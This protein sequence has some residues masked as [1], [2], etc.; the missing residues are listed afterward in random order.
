MQSAAHLNWPNCENYNTQISKTSMTDK[1]A[2]MALIDTE[3][4]TVKS[5]FDNKLNALYATYLKTGEAAKA[6]EHQNADD[7]EK[8]DSAKRNFELDKTRDLKRIKGLTS[9][10]HSTMDGL[11][12][13]YADDIDEEELFYYAKQFCNDRTKDLWY[14]IGETVQRLKK[15]L[16]DNGIPV[17]NRIDEVTVS[18]P[19]VNE[20]EMVI[21]QAVFDA[22]DGGVT[23]SNQLF[24]VKG[25]KVAKDIMRGEEARVKAELKTLHDHLAARVEKSKEPKNSTVDAL[26]QNF[27]RDLVD[28]H[29]VMNGQITG[30]LMINRFVLR[31]CTG[32]DK[33]VGILNC[34]RIHIGYVKN[35]MEYDIKR[36]VNLAESLTYELELV[37]H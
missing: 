14:I 30:Q 19:N 3:M 7:V 28:C 17:L 8:W 24:C 32:L 11:Y 34:A 18:I 35:T 36:L 4:E 33:I 25:M 22:I 15:Q 37:H 12:K 29:S 16:A 2:I 21:V 20:F 9:T 10:P 23:K 5:D 13:Q 6:N 27:E 31:E 1:A 26:I